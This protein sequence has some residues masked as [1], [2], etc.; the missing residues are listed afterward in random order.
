M[1]GWFTNEDCFLVM[2]IISRIIMNKAMNANILNNHGKNARFVLCF[3]RISM[4][5]IHAGKRKEA[6]QY[7][8]LCLG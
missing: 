8:M 7:R 4:I 6:K 1:S 2:K 5:K 3:H